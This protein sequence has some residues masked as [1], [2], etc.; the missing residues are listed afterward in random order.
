MVLDT[1]M[2]CAG[3]GLE[4]LVRFN[5]TTYMLADRAVAAVV[6]LSAPDSCFH[7]PCCLKTPGSANWGSNGL[8]GIVGV[9][10]LEVEEVTG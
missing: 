10:L 3:C 8:L 5:I 2:V 7:K 9:V 1:N 6:R 4:G